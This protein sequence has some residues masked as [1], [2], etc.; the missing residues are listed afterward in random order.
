MQKSSPFNRKNATQVFINWWLFYYLSLFGYCV[1]LCRYAF[2]TPE[3]WTM[4]GHFR[5]LIYMRPLSIW[6]MQ[7]AL[8]SSKT[9]L[10]APKI[11]VMDRTNVTSQT[12]NSSQSEGA[13]KKI[14]SKAKCFGDA[15]FH[16]SC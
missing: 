13:V 8:L 2:Q 4:D 6:G 5:S 7:W 3:G 15:V 11:N 12:V 9:M 10:E 16:C 1:C 14:A